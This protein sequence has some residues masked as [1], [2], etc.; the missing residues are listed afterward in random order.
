MPGVVEP[1]TFLLEN[2]ALVALGEG[3]LKVLA[4]RPQT[5]AELQRFAQTTTNAKK[6]GTLDFSGLAG[7]LW[8]TSE[9]SLVP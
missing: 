2:H 5:S 9:R 4:A 6:A 1:A 7:L 8:I 3:V